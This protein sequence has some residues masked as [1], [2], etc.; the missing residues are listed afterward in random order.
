MYNN[1]DFRHFTRRYFYTTTIVLFNNIKMKAKVITLAI[2]MAIQA[3]VS[4]TQLRS[5]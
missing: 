5:R 3:M 1:Y 4:A 2:F